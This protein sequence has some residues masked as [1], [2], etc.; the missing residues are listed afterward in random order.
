MGEDMDRCLL[1]TECN[2][3]QVPRD[4][5]LL[6]EC[7]NSQVPKDKCPHNTTSPNNLVVLDKCLLNMDSLNSQELLDKLSSHRWICHLRAMASHH[8]AKHHKAILH[9]V[10]DSNLP[11]DIINSND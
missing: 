1:L 4:N 2:N 5:L 9:K 11:K 3:S 6:T 8:K 7:N 10:S